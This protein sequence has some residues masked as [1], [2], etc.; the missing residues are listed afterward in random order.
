MAGH[1]QDRIHI[2]IYG[3]QCILPGFR[4]ITSRDVPKNRRSEWSRLRRSVAIVCDELIRAKHLTPCAHPEHHPDVLKLTL[5]QRQDLYKV[6]FYSLYGK[7]ANLSKSNSY[8][9]V[10]DHYNRLK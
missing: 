9:S 1:G 7:D 6:A 3:T 2:L 4:H 8:I 5:I 10:Y